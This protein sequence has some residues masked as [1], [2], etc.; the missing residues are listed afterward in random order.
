MGWHGGRTA[1]DEEGRV[2]GV[3][4]RRGR[5]LVERE[6]GSVDRREARAQDRWKVVGATDTE[7]GPGEDCG[8]ATERGWLCVL[9]WCRTTALRT[10]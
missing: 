2:P 8:Q 6:Q 1:C 5:G 10:M 7:P 3:A 4:H 9:G